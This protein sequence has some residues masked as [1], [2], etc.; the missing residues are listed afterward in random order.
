MTALLL[1]F[2]LTAPDPC[3]QDTTSWKSI[4]HGQE[5]IRYLREGQAILLA[6]RNLGKQPVQVDVV[7]REL[8][9]SGVARLFD[10]TANK[11]EGKVQAGFARKLAPG[12]CAAYRLRVE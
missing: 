9:F 4:R 7:W 10:I 3:S 6:V 11:D 12:A 5:E 8:G 1:L 2:L